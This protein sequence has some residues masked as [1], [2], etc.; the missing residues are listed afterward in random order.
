MICTFAGKNRA[1]TACAR[2]NVPLQCANV[3]E[4]ETYD[5]GFVSERERF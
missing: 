2:A 5:D 1:K 3:K 4:R